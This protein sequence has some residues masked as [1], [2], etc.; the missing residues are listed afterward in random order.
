LG[1]MPGRRLNSTQVRVSVQ[2]AKVIGKQRKT[3]VSLATLRIHS[4]QS[5]HHIPLHIDAHKLLR[6]HDGLTLSPHEALAARGI[7]TLGLYKYV[8]K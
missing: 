5:M 2:E 4:N 8:S 1:W 6:A 3:H 7:R